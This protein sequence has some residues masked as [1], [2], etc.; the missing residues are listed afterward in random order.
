[1]GN[2][3]IIIDPYEPYRSLISY[4]IQTSLP[5]KKVAVF[6]KTEDAWEKIEKDPQAIAI[7]IVGHDVFCKLHKYYIDGITFAEKIKNSFSHINII[8]NTS[9]HVV[10]TENLKD[11]YWYNPL[12]HNINDILCFL[13]KS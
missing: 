7:V 6:A 2:T 13:Q 12:R 9:E 8:L 1:M 10:L 5:E 3:V 4:V 11:I